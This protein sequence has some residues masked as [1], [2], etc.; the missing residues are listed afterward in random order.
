MAF[1]DNIERY[2]LKLTDLVKLKDC[3]F[4]GGK[5]RIECKPFAL[6][7]FVYGVRCTTCNARTEESGTAIKAAKNWNR[8]VK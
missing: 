4:C 6:P 1:I 7:D 8:R 3:P 5:A 2:P